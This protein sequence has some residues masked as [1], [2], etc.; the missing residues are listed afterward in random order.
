MEWWTSL[1]F[2]ISLLMV[3]FLSG[4]PVAFSFFLMNIIGAVVFMGGPFALK[5]L[6][7]SIYDSLAVFV[8][9]PVPLFILMGE[10]MFHSKM[11]NKAMDVLEMWLGKIPGRLGLV[12][13][14]GGTI[15]ASLTG[16]QMANTAMLGSTLTPAMQARG[17]S[18]DMSMGPVLGAGGIAIMIPPSSLAV[19]LGSLAYIPISRILIGGILPGLMMAFFYTGYV[20][21]RCVLNPGIAPI[22]DLE[23]VTWR[24]KLA[25]LAKYVLPLGLVVFLVIGL[26]LLGVATPSESAALGVFGTMFLGY[27]YGGLKKRQI[28]D[29][30]AG[31]CKV[32]VAVFM[33]IAGATFFSQL[34]SFTGAGRGLV[35][36]VVE[37]QLS[38]MLVL[39]GM[40]IVLLFLGCFMEQVCMMMITIPLFMPIVQRLGFDPLW[41]GIMML[42]TLEIAATSPPFGLNLFVMKGVAPEGTSMTEIYLAALPYIGCDLIVLTIVALFP[43]LALFLPNTIK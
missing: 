3:L 5:Q 35:N 19:I 32:T 20:V 42:I 10:L 38:P 29:S 33:I 7:L 41:F 17:Y 4:L 12:A 31:T 26:I 24:R 23:R 40:M 16:S 18:R 11:A 25:A 28:I 6:I 21:L 2:L 43:Q 14:I 30:I 34:L 22:Y 1:I 15:F 13:I 36:Y 8:F 37:M 27:L 39:A 9:A